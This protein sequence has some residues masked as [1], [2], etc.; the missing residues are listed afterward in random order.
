MPVNVIY[1][2]KYR[3]TVSILKESKSK[4]LLPK[5]I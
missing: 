2:A 1:S 3:D 5:L 4:T